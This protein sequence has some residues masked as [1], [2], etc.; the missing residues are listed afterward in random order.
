MNCRHMP[1]GEIEAATSVVTARARNERMPSLYAD[2]IQLHSVG[3]LGS[4]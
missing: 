1:Q 4:D 3:P 2:A